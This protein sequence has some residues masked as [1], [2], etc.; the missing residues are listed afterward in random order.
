MG[1]R[2]TS[3]HDMSRLITVDQFQ[4]C[5][6]QEQSSIAGWVGLA[7]AIHKWLIFGTPGKIILTILGT[8]RCGGAL[9]HFGGGHRDIAQ[10]IA[11]DLPCYLY[12]SDQIGRIET[13]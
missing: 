6:I 12:F 9:H 11:G 10:S 5:I 4:G 13:D 7:S 1:G 3:K 2:D 8:G